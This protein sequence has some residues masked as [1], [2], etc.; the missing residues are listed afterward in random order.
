MNTN[1]FKIVPTLLFL[2]RNTDLASETGVDYKYTVIAA[3]SQSSHARECPDMQQN[4]HYW[5]RPLFSK[6]SNIND[7]FFSSH[8]ERKNIYP[9]VQLNPTPQSK[10]S[11]GLLQ[12][13][14]G[15][16]RN[17]TCSVSGCDVDSMNKDGVQAVQVALGCY[18][19]E[20]ESRKYLA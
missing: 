15:P 10:P 13:A 4:L 18:N 17:P 6:F 19:V 7:H 20:S 9:I 12:V 11:W 3:Q 14:R 2:T 16:L 8:R 1:S 5:T